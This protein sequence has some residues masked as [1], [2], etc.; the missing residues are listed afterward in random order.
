[1]KTP[2]ATLTLQGDAVGAQPLLHVT[3]GTPE[4]PF[5]RM[6]NAH[7]EFGINGALQEFIPAKDPLGVASISAVDVQTLGKLETPALLPTHLHLLSSSVTYASE[8]P[9][10]PVQTDSEAV[11]VASIEPASPE[12]DSGTP[13]VSE[14][15]KE[16]LSPI[17][18]VQVADTGTTGNLQ[19]EE[20]IMN[21]PAVQ[22]TQATNAQNTVRQNQNDAI[23]ADSSFDRV[24]DQQVANR[25]QDQKNL[26]KQSSAR[27]KERSENKDNEAS[28]DASEEV[29]QD[30]NKHTEELARTT[31][32]LIIE[33]DV[34]AHALAINH[35]IT[36]AEALR[37][38]QL[39]TN[40]LSLKTA[41]NASRDAA[42]QTGA[43][44]DKLAADALLATNGKQAQISEAL[45]K[46]NIDVPASDATA[47]TPSLPITEEAPAGAIKLTGMTGLATPAEPAAMRPLTTNAARE[48][49]SAKSNAAAISLKDPAATAAIMAA[50]QERANAEG[51][52]QDT[53]QF[54]QTELR[55]TASDVSTKD[56][57]TNAFGTVLA[58]GLPTTANGMPQVLSGLQSGA[59]GNSARLHAQVGHQG[60]NQALG[61]H[62]I[63]MAGTAQ[64]TATLTLN[65]PDLGPLQVVL[66]VQNAQADATFI[67]AQ[68]E[69]K[70]A[71]EAA[72][73]RLRE[74]MEQAGIELGQA[75]VN[76]GSPQQQETAQQQYGR[77]AQA[78]AKTLNADTEASVPMLAALPT[79][80]ANGRGMVDV[81][82]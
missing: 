50:Q 57:F 62:M 81:F 8:T 40:E 2:L 72:L 46:G 65:P 71:L 36:M 39:P 23:S 79:T 9:E 52:K 13:D 78:H 29:S 22:I 20:E 56:S 10:L 24:L 11:V 69:V 3:S 12:F 61:Q 49:A 47:T 82:A 33:P 73:P 16:T 66:Q 42:L 18:D 54:A 32:A 5:A 53:Q 25:Q 17:D 43:T 28:A 44:Q 74:M 68:P 60:W 34:S 51:G 4:S 77:G 1:M 70:Q 30:S 48:A 15:Q 26:E 27:N 80:G 37:P 64:Q 55:T 41:L 21:T 75:T 7:M 76:T 31:P 14:V 63:M 38:T 45:T 67:T 58:T 59:A 35:A 6:L 19:A